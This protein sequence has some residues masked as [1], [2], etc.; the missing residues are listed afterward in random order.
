[1]RRRPFW[2]RPIGVVRCA[3]AEPPRHWSVSTLEGELHLQERYREGLS[4]IRPGERI[5]V[6]F[7]FHRS[8]PFRRRHLRPTPPTRGEAQGV[9]STCSP[10]RPN[11]L[12]LSVV[13]VLEVRGTVLR[14]RGLDMYDGTPI[15][16]LK[17]HKG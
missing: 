15:L 13:E 17:P 2:M 11:P 1:M 7:A 4:D 5:V 8:P 12:G 16:D 9:F 3:A 6:L 10:V 14:V